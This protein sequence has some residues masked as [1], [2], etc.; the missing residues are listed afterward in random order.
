MRCGFKMA[1]VFVMGGLML[2]GCSI[3]PDEPEAYP[4][5]SGNTFDLQNELAVVLPVAERINVSYEF[6]QSDPA[7]DYISAPGFF[8]GP[9]W[10]FQERTAEEPEQF[11]AIHL[12][13]RDG[14]EFDEAPGALV[15]LSRTNY[16]VQTYCF[17][18]SKDTI[19]PEIQ[20]YLDSFRDL[21]LDVSTD[22]YFRRFIL[23]KER[24]GGE[25]TDLVYIRDIVRLGYTCEAIG[26]LTEPKPGNDEIVQ[27]LQT[28]SQAA[29][30]VMS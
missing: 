8:D 2:A 22:I 17:D 28:D 25:R 27:Q 19:P 15:R 3:N 30:E 7:E 11:L 18:L 1:A 4:K 21:D 12:L 24:E 10:W 23:R 13:K 14:D 20:P 6:V 16:D 5:V 9:I 26:D 29:F